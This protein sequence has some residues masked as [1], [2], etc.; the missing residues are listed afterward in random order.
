MKKDISKFCN[1]MQKT[2]KLKKLM[3]SHQV[4]FKL[5]AF[6]YTEVRG[7]RRKCE[8]RESMSGKEANDLKISL[9]TPQDEAVIFFSR[10]MTYQKSTYGFHERFS[11]LR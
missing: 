2:Q 1:D 9:S 11:T 8:R 4:N 5:P 3:I 10:Y 6:V 7:E